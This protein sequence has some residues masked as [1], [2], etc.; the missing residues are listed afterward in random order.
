MELQRSAANSRAFRDH[1][2]AA[3]SRDGFGPSATLHMARCF[4]S[5]ALIHAPVE[6]CDAGIEEAVHVD[7][8]HQGRNTVQALP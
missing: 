7:Q 3:A 6:Q 8:Y 4:S 5:M 1:C 2:G